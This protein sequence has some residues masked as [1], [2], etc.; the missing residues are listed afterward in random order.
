VR[1]RGHGLL[2]AILLGAGVGGFLG[3][4]VG[5]A[6]GAVT[7]A[8]VGW[9]NEVTLT[10]DDYADLFLGFGEYSML[11]MAV[12]CAVLGMLYGGTGGAAA[13]ASA[14]VS[15][16]QTVGLAVGV[17]LP[18]LLWAATNLFQDGRQQAGVVW[19]ASMLTG[20]VAAGLFCAKPRGASQ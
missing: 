12:G 11:G 5:L 10:G 4:T 3:A 15:H 19:C 17:G 7:G 18:L 13:G 20:S 16:R 6:V 14:E 8:A 1:S 2:D 9:Y